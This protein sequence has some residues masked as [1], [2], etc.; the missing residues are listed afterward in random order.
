MIL[1]IDTVEVGIDIDEREIHIK[2]PN[3]PQYELIIPLGSIGAML[4][5]HDTPTDQQRGDTTP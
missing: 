1:R 2:A 4:L 5:E 3:M